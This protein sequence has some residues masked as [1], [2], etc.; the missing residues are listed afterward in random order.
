MDDVLLNKAASIERSS[1]RIA[2]EYLG[3]EHE[4]ETN[5]TRQDAL[6]LNLQRA[7]ETS[8]NAAMHIVRI[9]SLG[10]PQQSR[11][12]FKLAAEAGLLSEDLSQR[13]QAMVGFRNV[14]VHMYTELSIA[15]LRSIL[16]NNI[17]DLTQF[18]ALL[19]K[20]ADDL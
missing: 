17:K 14:A 2:E 12:A 7:C 13:M 10:A 19:I 15:I 9:K 20:L 1:A 4:L 18:A 3:Y 8:I 6:V 11:D 5:Q 16:K